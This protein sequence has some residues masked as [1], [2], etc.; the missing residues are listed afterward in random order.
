MY[1]ISNYNC[2]TNFDAIVNL[3]MQFRLQSAYG[4][5]FDSSWASA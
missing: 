1:I 3:K 5:Y 4:N 2:V